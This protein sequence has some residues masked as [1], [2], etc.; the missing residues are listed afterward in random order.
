MRMT[1]AEM[2]NHL[3]ALQQKME[4]PRDELKKLAAQYAETE[5]ALMKRMTKEGID[6]AKGKNALVSMQE[7]TSYSIKNRRLFDRYVKRNKAFDLFQNR[8]NSTALKD[9]MEAG[10]EIPGVE[11]FTRKGISLRKRR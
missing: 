5:M 9:R 6:S 7:Y 3:V 10:E 4:R 1:T 11:A 8:V 2:I